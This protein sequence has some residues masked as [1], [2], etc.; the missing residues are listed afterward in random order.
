MGLVQ[1]GV[2]TKGDRAL[3]KRLRRKTIFEEDNLRQTFPPLHLKTT[4][5]QCLATFMSG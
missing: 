4:V 1:E 2:N 5:S 3:L